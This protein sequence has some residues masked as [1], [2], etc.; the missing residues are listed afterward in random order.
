MTGDDMTPEYNKMIEKKRRG[1][2]AELTPAFYEIKG[3]YGYEMSDKEQEE[4]INAYVESG[5]NAAIRVLQRIRRDA[6]VLRSVQFAPIQGYRNDPS[7][8]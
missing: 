7:E 8:L 2:I 4:A 6:A 3:I 1:A 5:R